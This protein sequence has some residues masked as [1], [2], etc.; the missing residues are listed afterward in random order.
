MTFADDRLVENQRKFRYAN[1]RLDDVV[2]GA[3]LDGRVVPFFCECPDEK[4]FGRIEL[5]PVDYEEAHMLPD[6]YLIL[7][8][9]PRAEH[10]EIL[11]SRGLFE[12]VQ[13]G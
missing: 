4:C 6:T 7:T 12:V 9:H 10:E 1:E 13:K 2:S 11:E 5:R 8:G 3:D